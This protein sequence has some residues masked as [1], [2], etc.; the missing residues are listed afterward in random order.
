[1]YPQSNIYT[2]YTI[3]FKP[4]ALQSRRLIHLWG[5]FCSHEHLLLVCLPT[6]LQLLEYKEDQTG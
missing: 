6:K 1:M 2:G 3:P 4:P 5:G